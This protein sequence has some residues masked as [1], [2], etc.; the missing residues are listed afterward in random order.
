MGR[1]EA[2]AQDRRLYPYFPARV[3]GGGR[4]N[5]WRSEGHRQAQPRRADAPRPRHPFPASWTCSR[6]TSRCSR[7]RR[8]RSSSSPQP[9]QAIELARIAND[10]MAELVR[11]HPDRF[12]AFAAALPMNDPR[13]PRRSAACRD[14]ARREGHSDPLQRPR[15]ADRLRPSFCRCSRRWWDTICRSGC[16]RIAAPTSRTT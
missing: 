8:R 4:T 14:R 7:C 15:Q 11:K 10:S 5:C 1:Q 9:E 3:L 6:S 16:I 12:V 13:P 2:D